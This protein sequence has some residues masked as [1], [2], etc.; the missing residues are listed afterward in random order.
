MADWVYEEEFAF[1]KGYEWSS[2]GKYLAY[3]KFDDSEVPLIELDIKTDSLYTGQKIVRYPKTGQRN[4][5]V[6]IQLYN[7]INKKTKELPVIADNNSY[8]PR[9]Q[10]QGNA[11]KLAIFQMNRM[12]NELSILKYDVFDETLYQFYKEFNNKYI[13]LPERTYFTTDGSQLLIT[14][15]LSQYQQL[16]LHSTD[17][18]KTKNIT[19]GKYDIDEVYGIDEN[20]GK[21]YFR[22]AIKDPMNKLIYSADINQ[23]KVV[24]IG[25]SEGYC[26]AVYHSEQNYIQIEHSTISTPEIHAIYNTAGD[27][28]FT[29]VDNLKIWNSLP[30]Y[31]FKKPEFINIKTV[32]KIS[33]NAWVIKPKDFNF[34]NKYPLIIYMYGGPGSQTVLNKWNGQRY[35]WHQMMAQKGYIIVS[36]DNRGTGSRGE[37][38]NKQVYRKLGELEAHDQ[39]E[40]AKYFGSKTSSN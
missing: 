20:N 4:P 38:F 2:D 5:D 22:A 16:Y 29:L 37:A 17:T 1:H 24:N 33:L 7:T 35:M 30:D 12:Q 34:K 39:I 6:N 40:V 27:R 19:L 3:L 11:H 26:S 8:I 10:W 31:G 9:I 14:N 36:S 18:M 23:F 15:N 32:D 25:P 21:V 28:L 13:E